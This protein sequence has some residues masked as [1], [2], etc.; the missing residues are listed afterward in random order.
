MSNKTLRCPLCN[1]KLVQKRCG[2]VC[3]NHQCLFYWK[4]GGWCLKNP[5]SSVWHYTDNSIDKQIRWDKAHGY[6]PLHTKISKRHIKAMHATLRKNSD[7]CF[8][9]P[10]R[11]Y[12]EDSE[13]VQEW[14][15]MYNYE[16]KVVK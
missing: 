1:R 9:I 10:L 16:I 14:R 6:P 8:V 7:L 12:S 5:G 3:K 13:V 2:L 15:I 4:L 11:Y